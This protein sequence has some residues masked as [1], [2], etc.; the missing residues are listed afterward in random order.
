MKTTQFLFLENGLNVTQLKNTAKTQLKKLK[1]EGNKKAKLSEILDSLSKKITGKSYKSSLKEIKDTAPYL[2][3]GVFYMP[4]EN[5]G[6]QILVKLETLSN[7]DEIAAFKKTII[8]MGNYEFEVKL[9]DILFFPELINIEKLDN[10]WKLNL[11]ITEQ[12]KNLNGFNEGDEA[13]F[14]IKKTDEGLVIDYY[15]TEYCSELK[16]YNVDCNESTYAFWDELVVEEESEMAIECYGNEIT[17]V[18]MSELENLLGFELYSFSGRA[19]CGM[20]KN[21]TITHNAITL[22]DARKVEAYMKSK[23][24]RYVGYYGKED[25]RF[26]NVSNDVSD[27]YYLT[28]E[29]SDA[30]SEYVSL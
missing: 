12:A 11:Y 13:W 20:G 1:K 28:G 10:G 27:W 18:V 15:S 9:Y 2:D 3:N 21:L 26:Y 6:N 8:S 29:Q 23:S 14:E 30:P 24:L 22:E 17:N 4:F 25:N 19:P 7:E 5:E 16:G